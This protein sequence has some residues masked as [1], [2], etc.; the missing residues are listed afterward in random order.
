[1]YVAITRARDRLYI[2]HTQSRMLH[3]QV[4][5]NL[6]SRFLEE[7]PKQSVKIL[8]PKPKDSIWSSHSRQIN[9]SWGNTSLNTNDQAGR[10]SSSSSVLVSH[11][12]AKDEHG[13]HVGQQVFHSKFGEGR[14]I[15][16]EGSGPDTKA[17][18]NFARHGTKW[19]QLS[20]AKLTAI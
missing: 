16:F 4:R 9:P 20:I 17:Q 11:T 10:N 2:S 19:L 6:P 13:F 3:G 1:M 7:L 5:Y 8:T 18:V 15:S 12:R 14:I